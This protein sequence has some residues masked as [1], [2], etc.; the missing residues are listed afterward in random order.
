MIY[1]SIEIQDSTRYVNE[2]IDISLKLKTCQLVNKTNT[3]I[4]SCLAVGQ[5]FYDLFLPTFAKTQNGQR[6]NWFCHKC[7]NWTETFR[8]IKRLT[9]FFLGFSIVFTLCAS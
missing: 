5:W 3:K 9:C 7:L 8:L 1:I 4:I 6:Q 2:R